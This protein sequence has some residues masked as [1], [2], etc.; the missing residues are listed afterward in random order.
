M[1][2]DLPDLDR[3]KLPSNQYK[4]DAAVFKA[5]QKCEDLILLPMQSV[6]CDL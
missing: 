6:C 4:S 2:S 5:R 1:P 3:I